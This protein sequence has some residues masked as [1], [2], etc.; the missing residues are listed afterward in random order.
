LDN[1]ARLKLPSAF[2]HGNLIREMGMDVMAKVR[3]AFGWSWRIADA[4]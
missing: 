3:W 1:N 2:Y 4:K